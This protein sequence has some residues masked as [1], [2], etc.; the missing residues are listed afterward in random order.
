MRDCAKT[1]ENPED[2]VVITGHSQGGAIAAVAAVAL[3]DLDPYI[4]TFGQPYTLDAP[5]EKISSERFYRYVNSEYHARGIEYDPIPFVPAFISMR[6][7]L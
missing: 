7:F 6:S 3:A 2:C 1:C 4:I 5:C